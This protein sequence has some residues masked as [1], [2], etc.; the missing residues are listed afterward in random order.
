MI[1]KE[2]GRNY[3]SLREQHEK[4]RITDSRLDSSFYVSSQKS[5]QIFG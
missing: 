5:P 4:S 3:V 2:R 1:F